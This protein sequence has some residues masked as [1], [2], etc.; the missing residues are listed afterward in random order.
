[1]LRLALGV[2]GLLL[3]SGCDAGST[4]AGSTDASSGTLRGCTVDSPPPVAPGGY[5]TNGTTVC[6]ADGTPHL[7]HGVDRPSM[8][9]SQGEHI[10]AVRFCGHGRLARERRSRR[11]QSGFLALGRG[12]V[13]PELPSD[14]RPGRAFCRSRRARRDPR[15]AL[16]RSR[17]SE[18]RQ[19]AGSKPG[20]HEQSAANGG[21]QLAAILDARS[22]PSTSTTAT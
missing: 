22:R 15:F 4:S 21:R 6:S 20:R 7:F 3:L 17:R 2:L 11:A 10:G 18:R 12:A 1:M 13:Q 9:W 16:V 8:E 5:Y 19:A 14:R